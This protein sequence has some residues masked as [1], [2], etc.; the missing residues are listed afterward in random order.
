MANADF[1]TTVRNGKI[2]KFKKTVVAI[3]VIAIIAA[4]GI[5]VCSE[6]LFFV[7]GIDVKNLSEDEYL[8]SHNPYTEEEMLEG[9]GIK[10]ESG[11][12]DFDASA[13]EKSAKYSLPYIKEIKISRRWPSTVVAKVKFE[14]PTYYISVENNLYILSDNLK[15]LER[16]KDY[17][18]IELGS[19]ILL[20]CDGIHNCIVGE[21]LGIP[22]D[23]EEIIA[24]IDKHIEA[25]EVKKDISHINVSDMFNLSIM[26]GTKYNVKLGDA[27]NIETKIEFMKRV[28][29]NRTDDT[30][31][32]TI[33][34]SDV[35]KKKAAYTKFV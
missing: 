5:F 26:Y 19:L 16:T 1:D 25:F 30:S 27:K 2:N 6:N 23:I 12:Y 15:V 34:V 35:N 24:E 32:G 9:L 7:K 4:L 33:D 13:A 28:I 20:E 3:A 18:K 8:S 21:K 29:E 11:L 17:E 14:K 31:G 10:K 22:K